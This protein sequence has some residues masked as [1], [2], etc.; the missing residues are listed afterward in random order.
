MRRIALVSILLMVLTSALLGQEII[1]GFDYFTKKRIKEDPTIIENF[2]NQE[3]LL[4]GYKQFSRDYKTVEITIPV[5]VHILHTGESKGTGCNISDAQVFSAIEWLN[6]AFAGQEDYTGPDAGIKFSLASRT[7]DCFATSGI[8]RKNIRTLCSN[9]DCYLSKGITYNNENAIKSSSRWPADSYLNIWVVREIEDNSAGHGIQGFATFPGGDSALDGVVVLHNAFGY[10]TSSSAFNL[11]SYTN[12]NTTLVHEIGHVLGLY[13]TF[14][15][16][17]MNRD[18]YGDR[19]PSFTGCGLFHGDCITDTPPHIRSNG[20]CNTADVN[21][22]DGGTSMDLYIHNFM[23]Y[24]G[25]ECQHE[26]TQGQIDRVHT[27]LETS[28]LPWRNSMGHIPVT[29]QEPFANICKPQTKII[30]NPFDMGIHQLSIGTFVSISGNTKEDGGYVNNWCKAGY[31]KFG[32]PYPIS[33]E[34]G[35]QNYQNVKIFCDF[36]NDG[37]FDDRDETWFTSNA[38]KIHTGQVWV[39]SFASQGILLRLRVIADYAGYSIPNGCYTPAFGQVEDYGVVLGTTL[40]DENHLS[41]EGNIMEGNAFLSWQRDPNKLVE[42]YVI[43]KLD[44]GKHFSQIGT[45]YPTYL[46]GNRHQFSDHLISEDKVIYRVNAVGLNGTIIDSENIH[47]HAQTP[48]ES[49]DVFPNPVPGNTIFIK[50]KADQITNFQTAEILDVMGGSH[51][52]T[53]FNDQDMNT[54]LMQIS[55]PKL[56]S[57]IYHIKFTTSQGVYS[58]KFVK[59]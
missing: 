34:T 14:E 5:V 50:N 33:V 38:A 27:I 54:L 57:G 20:N 8:V 39:P 25:Q 9:G 53:G 13:H 30:N 58:E 11:K 26:F 3:T 32:K 56:P 46:S 18:G 37:D 45:V 19:C 35:E 36:N 23:D 7:P 51:F 10:Q 49:F 52:Y 42:K 40:P 55:V 31:F 17:D 1:D 28:R 22:C 15:G 21:V 16:D 6:K 29:S 4:K 12:K 2:Q 48:L 44:N 43:E 59:I 47:L 41:L 24:S